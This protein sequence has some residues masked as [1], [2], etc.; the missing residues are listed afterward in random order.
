MIEVEV[1]VPLEGIGSLRSKLMELDCTC[2]GRE[3]HEDTYY[4]GTDRDFAATDEALR[5]RRVDGRC[6]ITYK[7]PKIG[8]RSKSRREIELE[9]GN[10]A[11]ADEVLT[12]LGFTRVMTVTK[13][14][15]NYR[16]GRYIISLDTVTDLG[17]YMEIETDAEN[18]SEVPPKVEEMTGL[19]GQLG[20]KQDA[21][22]TES[23]LELLLEKKG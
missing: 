5:L 6:V 19:L 2:L 12:A 16:W 21:V 23:Y 15:E 9:V 13:T 18:E 22:I 4:N 7:G 1:K 17:H 11:S 3:G 14:R 20:I 8:T 10:A